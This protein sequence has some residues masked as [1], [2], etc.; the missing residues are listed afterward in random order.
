MVP[1]RRQHAEPVLLAAGL[2]AA[3]WKLPA[4]PWTPTS[5]FF[6]LRASICTLSRAAINYIVTIGPSVAKNGTIPDFPSSC[7]HPQPA[8][9]RAAAALG[10]P[11]AAVRSLTGMVSC[12]TLGMV[13]AVPGSI[14]RPRGQKHVPQVHL[15]PPS[16]GLV[17]TCD[18]VRFPRRCML[19]CSCVNSMLLWPC[20]G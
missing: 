18:C 11:A 4:E 15:S 8:R 16:R 2:V 7:H 20:V 19:A 17:L 14:D 5:R 9:Q 6:F 3:I 1:S 10:R 12:Q 13:G